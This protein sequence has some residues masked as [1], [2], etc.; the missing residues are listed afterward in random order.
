[1]AFSTQR[2]FPGQCYEHNLLAQ[3]NTMKGYSAVKDHRAWSMDQ[4]Q[5]ASFLV[6]AVHKV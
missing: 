4:N 3:I 6:D 1:M 5:Q 2:K